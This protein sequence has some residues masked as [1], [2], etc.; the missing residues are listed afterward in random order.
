MRKKKL[1]KT[2]VTVILEYEAPRWTIGKNTKN[3]TQIN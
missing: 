2:D 3:I 1:N